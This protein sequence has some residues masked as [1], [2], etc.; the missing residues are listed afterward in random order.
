MNVGQ[1]KYIASRVY[2]QLD[3]AGYTWLYP[4]WILQNTATDTNAA[5]IGQ[6]KTVFNFDFFLA[7]PSSPTV[8]PGTSGTLDSQLDERLGRFCHQLRNRTTARQW[9]V[10][11]HC[12][13]HQPLHHFVRGEQ[14]GC[15]RKIPPFSI[16]ARNGNNV[17]VAQ[18]TPADPGLG[19]PL[20]VTEVPGQQPGEV[21]VFWQNNSTDATYNVVW[22][23]TDDQIWKCR[24]NRSRFFNLLPCF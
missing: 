1:L 8:T 3:A 21:D 18:E 13:C 15:G 17:S 11:Q 22:I 6:L 23:S 2:A 20:N 16:I 14:S 9:D 5:T 24:G 19:T 12:Q 7:G 10:D 4:S